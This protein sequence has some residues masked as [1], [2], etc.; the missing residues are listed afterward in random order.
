M[1][2]TFWPQFP[3]NLL[4]KSQFYL[5]SPCQSLE[6]FR[7]MCSCSSRP[8][9]DVLWLSIRWGR[10]LWGRFLQVGV[11]QRPRWAARQ[12]CGPQVRHG[13]LHLAAGGGGGVRRQLTRERRPPAG[14][15]V[16]EL[17]PRSRT[18]IQNGCV[19]RT[20]CLRREFFSAVRFWNMP[21]FWVWIPTVEALNT[22]IIHRKYF[23]FKF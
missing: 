14:H 15:G 2:E 22:C 6:T 9:P 8:S 5:M 18:N 17:H 20:T 12:G 7:L 10:H 16:V 21:P 19:T 3:E 11:E 23:C 4:Y 1:E 13:L